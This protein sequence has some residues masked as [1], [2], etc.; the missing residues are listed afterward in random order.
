MQIQSS[1]TPSPY[2]LP[3]KSWQERNMLPEFHKFWYKVLSYSGC[4][5]VYPSLC[6][7]HHAIFISSEDSFHSPSPKPERP[8]HFWQL[9][10]FIALHSTIWHDVIHSISYFAPSFDIKQTLQWTQQTKN[11]CVWC[12]DSRR[13]WKLF[14]KQVYKT[15]HPS[16]QEKWN[17]EAGEEIHLFCWTWYWKVNSKQ[18]RNILCIYHIYTYIWSQRNA[19][20]FWQMMTEWTQSLWLNTTWSWSGSKSAALRSY[21]SRIAFVLHIPFFPSPHPF[22]RLPQ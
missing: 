20:N 11:P 4:L 7:P 2:P 13:E 9:A 21:C 12:L 1:L 10:F 17:E 6:L 18:A 8:I 5:D 22:L 19:E 14:H 15:V 3:Q 16:C